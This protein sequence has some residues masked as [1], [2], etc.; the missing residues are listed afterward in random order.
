MDGRLVV[1]LIPDDS[2]C[3]SRCHRGT[4]GECQASLPRHSQQL[5]HLSGSE[6]RGIDKKREQVQF[7]F[8]LLF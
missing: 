8:F 2:V 3:H 6:E 1:N 4:D 7:F 5:Q